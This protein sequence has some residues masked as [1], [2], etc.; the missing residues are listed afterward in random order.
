MTK[1]NYYEKIGLAVKK[2]A[3][4]ILEYPD[5]N[6]GIKFA[7]KSNTK[8]TAEMNRIAPKLSKL[9]RKVK[10]NVAGANDEATAILAEVYVKSVVTFCDKYQDP[11]TREMF[12]GK[13]NYNPQIFLKVLIAVPE[14]FKD[15]QEQSTS[16]SLFN[17]EANEEIVGNLQKPSKKS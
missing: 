13:D 10:F 14:L 12:E 15:I 6:V 1:E 11:D 5:F 16:L 2:N 4:V 9:E 3:E 17:E 7:G 8:Y